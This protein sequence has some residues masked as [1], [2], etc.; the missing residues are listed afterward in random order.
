[1]ASGKGQKRGAGGN[2][3]NLGKNGPPHVDEEWAPSTCTQEDLEEQVWE[4]I[5][6]D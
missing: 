4:G 2:G 5:L 3:G 1:M 6:P